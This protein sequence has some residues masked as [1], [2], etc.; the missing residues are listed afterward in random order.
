MRTRNLICQAT[1]AILAAMVLI[2]PYAARAQVP[3]GKLRII[4]FGAHPDDCELKVAGTAAK[5]AA[6]GHHVKLVSLTNGDI[7]HWAMAGGPL[8]QRRTAEVQKCAKILGTTSQVIDIHDG[9]LLPTLEKRTIV[10]NLI[11]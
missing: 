1:C 6:L 9:E 4:A 11:R 2:L 7:G 5:W 8:A 3:D 10:T